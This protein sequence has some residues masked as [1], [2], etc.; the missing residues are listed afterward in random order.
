MPAIS[1]DK[2]TRGGILRRIRGIITRWLARP[3]RHQPGRR[4]RAAIVKVDRLGDFV[5]AVSAI[6]RALAHFGEEECLLL[7]SPQVEPLAA[8]E[9]P[10][11]ARLVLPAA[12]G[13]KRLLREGRRA[14]AML[15]SISCEEAICLRHQRWDWDELILA[16]L[17]AER[18]HVLDDPLGPAY[19]SAR[20][21]FLHQTPGRVD[22]PPPSSALESP[23]A[24]LC[25]EL[26]MHR[27]LLTAV[28]DRAVTEEEVLPRFE[29]LGRN[30]TATGIVVLPFGSAKIRDF[31]EKLIRKVLKTVREHTPL[32]IKL[33]GDAGQRARLLR[34]AEWLREEG[35]SDVTCAAPA[36]VT[37]FVEAISGAK[38]VLTVETSA[39][40]LAAAFDRPAVVVMGGGHYGQFGPWRRSARQ[41]WLTNDMDCFGCNWRCVHP[42]PYCLT[43]ISPD[44]LSNALGQVI[45]E[46]TPA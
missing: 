40:H 21:T 12:V 30:P 27:Q 17:D 10:R 23:A 1:P 36:K 7:I 19:F 14:R 46:G 5:L 20:N 11:T 3:L 18:C 41:I 6:R 16:W 24:P 26:R 43:R 4:F 42:E 2:T 38:L 44:L 37:A 13:H 45:K 35:V 29:H 8:S 33:Y 25:R 32:P 28:F 34:L 39:A 15:R 9:F 31:P 22:F